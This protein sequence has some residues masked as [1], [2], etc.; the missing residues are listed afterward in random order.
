MKKFISQIFDLVNFIPVIFK[1]NIER[2]SKIMAPLKFQCSPWYSWI[3]ST[4]TLSSMEERKKANVCICIFEA[5]FERFLSISLRDFQKILNLKIRACSGKFWRLHLLGYDQLIIFLKHC[6]THLWQTCWGIFKSYQSINTYYSLGPI[7]HGKQIMNIS[8][9]SFFYNVN[10][11]FGH[12]SCS[13]ILD[14]GHSCLS[15]W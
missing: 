11:W 5:M 8:I 13:L 2:F 4:K 15:F 6:Q 9:I 7:R 14:W 12:L 3:C 1:L 10:L